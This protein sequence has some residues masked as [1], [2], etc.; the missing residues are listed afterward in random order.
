MIDKSC[1]LTRE[2][3]NVRM[4][5]VYSYLIPIL[6]LFFPFCKS[7]RVTICMHKW[8]ASNFFHSYAFTLSPSPFFCCVLHVHCTITTTISSFPILVLVSLLFLRTV[9][10]R[11]SRKNIFTEKGLVSMV[12][13]CVELNCLI[14]IDWSQW[15]RKRTA[16]NFN[17]DT[18]A[19]SMS[20]DGTHLHS[21]YIL[22]MI[23]NRNKKESY[24]YIWHLV[25]SDYTILCICLN[26]RKREKRSNLLIVVGWPIRIA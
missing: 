1:S 16:A 11:P 20:D 24:S 18:S 19:M 22:S 13:S 15:M 9:I 3:A 5:I 17:H 14:L 23:I 25:L 26:R 6:L 12:V 2:R 8:T 21:V 10:K 4:L 7:Q